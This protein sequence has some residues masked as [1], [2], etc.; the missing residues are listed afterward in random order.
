MFKRLTSRIRRIV[1]RIK[2]NMEQVGLTIAA[3]AI[4]IGLTVFVFGIM[5]ENKSIQWVA[6]SLIG[7]GFV[8][9]FIS[10]YYLWR[11]ER[12]EDI[13]FNTIHRDINNAI[14]AINKLTNEIRQERNDRNNS[15]S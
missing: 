9:L 3:T 11:R 7:I 10:L 4:P 1:E 6:L 12:K 5:G 8:S 2:E 14:S 13:K 15:N